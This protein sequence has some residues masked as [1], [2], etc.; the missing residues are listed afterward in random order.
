M[1]QVPIVRGWQVF[2][3][4]L[5]RGSGLAVRARYVMSHQSGKIEVLAVDRR[6]IYLRHHRAARLADRGLLMVCRRDDRACWFD[7]L[8]PVSLDCGEPLPPV[9]L[10]GDDA[11]GEL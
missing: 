10:P 7:E 3:S 8:E 5:T 1:F 6:H 4:A 9:D 11:C 2:R